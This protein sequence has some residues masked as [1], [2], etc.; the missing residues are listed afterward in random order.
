MMVV[1]IKPAR[2]GFEQHM[3]EGFNCEHADR[4]IVKNKSLYSGH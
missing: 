1:D 4:I 2:T 3:F